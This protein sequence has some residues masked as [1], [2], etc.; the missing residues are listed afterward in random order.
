MRC[1]N[2]TRLTNWLILKRPVDPVYC[3][4]PNSIKS[5]CDWFKSNFPG[6]ILYAVKTNPSEKVIRYGW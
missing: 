6:Q 5:A 1:K 4:R 3:I 2:L